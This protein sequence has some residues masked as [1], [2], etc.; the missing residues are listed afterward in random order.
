M[1]KREGR[2]QIQRSTVNGAEQTASYYDGDL[3]RDVEVPSYVVLAGSLNDAAKSM[4]WR[5]LGRRDRFTA[6]IVAELHERGG[7]SFWA[8]KL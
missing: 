8:V 2:V 1:S 5:L 7:P 4:G 6:D 3:D